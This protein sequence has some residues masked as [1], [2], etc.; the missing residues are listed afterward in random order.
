MTDNEIVTLSTKMVDETPWI[1]VRWFGFLR[2]YR[3][4]LGFEI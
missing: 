1:K 4:R 2:T 3:V